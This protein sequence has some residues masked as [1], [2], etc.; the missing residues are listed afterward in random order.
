MPKTFGAVLIHHRLS[1]VLV[2]RIGPRSAILFSL[3]I[4]LLIPARRFSSLLPEFIGAA[5][6]L[7]FGGVLHLVSSGK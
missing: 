7:V 2:A 4:E 6:Y 1:G 3:T 5:D